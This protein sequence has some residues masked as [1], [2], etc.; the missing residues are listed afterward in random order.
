MQ[1]CNG[2][3]AIER[4]IRKRQRHVVTHKHLS[5]TNEELHIINSHARHIESSSNDASSNV[6]QL[7]DQDPSSFIYDM[8]HTQATL[9][10]RT[11]CPA[12]AQMCC[13]LM[14]LSHP[15]ITRVPP[16]FR[17]LPVHMTSC[18]VISLS[19]QQRQNIIIVLMFIFIY[20]FNNHF[21][22]RRQ[23]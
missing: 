7:F 18:E 17:Y 15:I 8:S 3:C 19:Q 11:S 10:M 4:I 2:Y 23:L 5:D 16:Q 22:I 13:K 12:L 9:P 14:L 20:S 6:Y 21:R 1:F